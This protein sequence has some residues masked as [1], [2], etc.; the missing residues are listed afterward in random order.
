MGLF[1]FTIVDGKFVSVHALFGG[2]RSGHS[3]TLLCTLTTNKQ[4]HKQKQRRCRRSNASLLA[5]VPFSCEGHMERK[6]NR[7]ELFRSRQYQHMRP[8]VQK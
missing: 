6:K 7:T 1:V 8:S 4:T 5:V 2:D 3:Q